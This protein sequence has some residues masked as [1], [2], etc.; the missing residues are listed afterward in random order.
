MPEHPHSVGLSVAAMPDFIKGTRE[1]PFKHRIDP[2]YPEMNPTQ[3]SFLPLPSLD[4]NGYTFCGWE[5]KTTTALHDYQLWKAIVLPSGGILVKG[6][7][8]P[9][10]EKAE[11]LWNPS[12]HDVNDSRTHLFPADEATKKA[13][14]QLEVA[15]KKELSQVYKYWEFQIPAVLDNGI[16]S[17]PSEVIHKKL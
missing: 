16:L 13:Q 8:V 9:H 1:N 6:P 2:R 4:H 5:I 3:I 10:F 17:G 15:I 7:S 11:T 14:T 12:C